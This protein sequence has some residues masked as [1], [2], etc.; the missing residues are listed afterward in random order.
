LL[1]ASGQLQVGL[2][3][4][5]AIGPVLAGVLITNVGVSPAFLSDAATYA[6]AAL[7]LLG[8]APMFVATRRKPAQLSSLWNEARAGFRA[9]RA[10]RLMI[11]ALALAVACNLLAVTVEG[12][13]VPYARRNLGVGPVGIGLY[14][15]LAA[16]AA[17]VTTGAASRS[18][19]VSGT[20]MLAATIPAVGSVLLAGV[21][22]TLGTAALAMISVGACS[23]TLNAHFRAARQRR[24]ALDLQGR[25]AMSARFA[26]Y[27]PQVVALTAGGA[28]ADRFGSPTLFVILAA[29]AGVLIAIA[30]QGGVGQLR[31]EMASPAAH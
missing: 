26:L 5:L 13:L 24:F 25:V 6:I 28:L 4:A 7:L 17:L 2:F 12:Q 22:P 14:T 30:A 8:M 19:A 27:A 1:R 3:A 23:G 15:A 10:D 9:L 11:R 29:L 21:W 18:K 16:V 20:T 31:E